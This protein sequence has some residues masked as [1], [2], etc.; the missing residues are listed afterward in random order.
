MNECK[1]RFSSQSIDEQL[2]QLASLSA[3]ASADGRLI[4]DLHLLFRSKGPGRE[5]NAS[6]LRRAWKR[7]ST[8]RAIYKQQRRRLRDGA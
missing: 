3:C 8:D 2:D 4:R 7:F 1:E 6:L 5:S